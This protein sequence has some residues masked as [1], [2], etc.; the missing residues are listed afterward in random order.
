VAGEQRGMGD[1][2]GD[3]RLAKALGRDEHDVARA[4]EEVELH[5]GLDGLAVDA[6]RPVP[7]EVRE[8]LEGPEPRATDA[9]LEALLGPLARLGLGHVLEDLGGIP[10][11]LGRERDE[12]IELGRSVGQAE[13]LER[14]DEGAHDTPSSSGAEA[15]VA[16][17]WSAYSSS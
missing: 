14:F 16:L 10:P 6:A 11:P 9:T 8:R 5:R 17:S 2:L 7:I 15:G 12:V 1:V 13:G 4:V 3:H